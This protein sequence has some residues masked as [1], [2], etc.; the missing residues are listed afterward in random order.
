MDIKGP[1][2]RAKED[3]KKDKGEKIEAFLAVHLSRNGFS[4][5]IPEI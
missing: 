3:G 5:Y 2:V 4:L 1:N